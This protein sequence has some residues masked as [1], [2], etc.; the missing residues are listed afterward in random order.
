VTV[1]SFMIMVPFSLGLPSFDP[2]GPRCPSHRSQQSPSGRISGG[3]VTPPWAA[4]HPCYERLSP[5]PTP[6]PRW[7]SRTFRYAGSQKARTYNALWQLQLTEG[8][9]DGAV[10]RGEADAMQAPAR[11]M[12]VA[13]AGASP[14]YVDQL[15]PRWPDAGGF[16]SPTIASGPAKIDTNVHKTVAQDVRL[17]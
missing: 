1:V 12:S 15:D 16:N 9:T 13:P 5:D 6:P 11:A 2:T 17:D 3:L 8:R 4:S 10:S 7:L 14:H